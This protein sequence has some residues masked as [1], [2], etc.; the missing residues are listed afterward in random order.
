MNRPHALLRSLISFSYQ[1]IF[2]EAFFGCISP[3]TDLKCLRES[4]RSDSLSCHVS[5]ESLTSA[6]Q[7]KKHLHPSIHPSITPP[8][9]L[10][11]GDRGQSPPRQAGGRAG[12]WRGSQA[13]EEWVGVLIDSCS[14]GGKEEFCLEL[15][16][17]PLNRSLHDDGKSWAHIQLFVGK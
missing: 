8:A 7:R 2:W 11:A 15:P 6:P 13:A 17:A 1:D 3:A 16:D 4:S 10:T 5:A 12:G 9:V 14:V